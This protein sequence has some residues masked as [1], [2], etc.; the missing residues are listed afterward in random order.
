MDRGRD[1]GIAAGGAPRQADDARVKPG[2]APRYGLI[3]PSSP[4]PSFVLLLLGACGGGGGGGAPPVVSAPP[5]VPSSEQR[6][7]PPVLKSIS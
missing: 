3:L 2:P 6:N 7:P 4:F 5:V 1:A